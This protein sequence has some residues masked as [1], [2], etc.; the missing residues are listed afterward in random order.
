MSSIFVFL[1][2]SRNLPGPNHFEPALGRAVPSRGRPSAGCL[3]RLLQRGAKQPCR[4]LACV[5]LSQL[6][7]Q[8][9]CP[10]PTPTCP[11]LSHLFKGSSGICMPR[12]L[13]GMY[14]AVGV[15]GSGKVCQGRQS[16]G[17][18]RAPTKKSQPGAL[19]D[20]EAPVVILNRK[21]RTN[22]SMSFWS[23]F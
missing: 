8:P 11:A 17:Q 19:R 7:H 22:Q 3:G 13:Q 14:V 23:N 10:L 9:S 2:V 5:S 21:R 18:G 20:G 15:G 16:W 4:D 1:A 6:F 12:A